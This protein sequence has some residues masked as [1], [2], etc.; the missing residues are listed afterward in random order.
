MQP[1]D[2]E[3]ANI[4][5]GFE[6]PRIMSH[7]LSARLRALRNTHNLVFI[8][9]RLSVSWV[10]NFLCRQP[11]TNS[12]GLPARVLKLQIELHQSMLVMKVPLQTWIVHTNERSPLTALSFL[13]D[14][15]ICHG[16]F[17]KL[18]KFARN[19]NGPQTYFL[20]TWAMRS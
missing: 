2:F 18:A 11:I 5:S 19:V 16:C 15:T 12:S 9:A 14:V 17:S 6:T 20:N 8:E 4:R 10:P 7:T 13:S 1:S 3:S